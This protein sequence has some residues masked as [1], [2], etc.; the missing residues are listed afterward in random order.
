LGNDLD[1]PLTRFCLALEAYRR[2]P[3]GRVRSSEEFLAHFFP[4]D[5]DIAADLILRLMPNEVRGPILA[6]WGIRGA[7]AA[8]TDTN[9]KVEQVV[10][11]ALRAGDLDHVAFE[12]ALTP[13]LVITALPLSEWW[14]FWRTG[15]LSAPILSRAVITAHEHGLFDARWFLDALV[16]SDGHTRGID[17]FAAKLPKPE[18]AAWV[19]NIAEAGDATP[20]GIVKAL[21]WPK[22]LEHTSTSGMLGVL[23]AM[24]K[25]VGLLFELPDALAAV[26]DLESTFVSSWEDRKADRKEAAL[27]EKRDDANKKRVR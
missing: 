15:R 4:H 1:A 12:A 5:Q 8:L 6:G 11:D 9:E 17:V 14:M 10:H 24:V 26:D 19:H 2:T 20:E 3:E 7:K 25:K 16:A 23:D 13:E 22:L 21:G 18:L 27:R